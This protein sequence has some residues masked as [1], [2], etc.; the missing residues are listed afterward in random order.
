MLRAVLDTNV[1]VSALIVP[2]G[3]PAQILQLAQ[4]DRFT[5]LLSEEI[6]TEALE[7]LHRSRIRKRFPLSEEVVQTYLD[8]LRV[9]AT[10]IVGGP[11]ENV[12]ANDPP[13]N[14]ILACAVGGD[15]DYL[16][17]GND[18]FLRLGEHRGV[19]MVSPAEFLQVL[20][21]TESG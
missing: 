6:L 4:A 13:D 11:V 10:M 7:V 2:N 21:N 9:S 14:L 8:S 1:L 18:H 16:V 5:L 19:Q 15:A 12:I 20:R 17:S 3:K